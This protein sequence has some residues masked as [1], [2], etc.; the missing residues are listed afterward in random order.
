MMG[1][2][3][4]QRAAMAGSAGRASA[5]AQWLEVIK[6]TSTSGRQYKHDLY[7]IMAHYG[8]EKH[9]PFSDALAMLEDTSTSRTATNKAAIIAACVVIKLQVGKSV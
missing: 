8:R 1:E 3:Q 4:H 5:A 9:L 6:D 7:L 2:C